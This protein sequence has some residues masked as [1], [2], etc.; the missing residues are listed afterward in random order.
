ML[1]ARITLT[2]GQLVYELD[3]AFDRDSPR[4]G[5]QLIR[6][7]ANSLLSRN[8]RKTAGWGLLGSPAE[9]EIDTKCACFA[10]KSV[11]TTFALS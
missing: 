8:W 4:P 6:Q 3:I 10:P 5:R 11:D 9:L 7:P 2:P 1:S